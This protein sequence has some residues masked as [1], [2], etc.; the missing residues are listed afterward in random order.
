M[1][2][3][4]GNGGDKTQMGGG[5][6]EVG[7]ESNLQSMSIIEFFCWLESNTSKGIFLK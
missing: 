3:T 5:R 7:G 2:E 6:K 1:G 4:A